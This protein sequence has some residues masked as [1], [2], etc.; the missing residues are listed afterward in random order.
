MRGNTAP[1]DH[2]SLIL[3]TQEAGASD[4]RGIL[5]KFA[6][7]FSPVVRGDLQTPRLVVVVPGTRVLPG[8]HFISVGRPSNV[9]NYHWPIVT[10]HRLRPV[11]RMIEQR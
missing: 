2:E 4:L 11:A 6:D 3:P 7:H 10:I 8:T 1:C 9:S 5:E